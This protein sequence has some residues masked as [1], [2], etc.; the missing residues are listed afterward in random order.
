MLSLL[1]NHDPGEFPHL[2]DH[3]E[4]FLGRDLL[5]NFVCLVIDDLN[6]DTLGGLVVRELGVCV[7]E[8]CLSVCYLDSRFDLLSRSCCLCKDNVSLLA[9]LLLDTLKSS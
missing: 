4:C 9:E 6:G 2:T 8:M 5:D 3:V 1:V 7:S